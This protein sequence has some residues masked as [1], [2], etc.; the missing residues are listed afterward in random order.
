VLIARAVTPAGLS[1]GVV[2][3]DTFKLIRGEPFGEIELATGSFALSEVKLTAPVSPVV[4]LIMMAGFIR[5]EPGT[6]NPSMLGDF[7]QPPGSTRPDI[8]PYLYPKSVVSPCG[9][10][11]DVV[12]QQDLPGPLYIEPELAVVI[13]RKIKAISEEDAMSAVLGFTNFNDVTMGD[14]LP[15]RPRVQHLA[16]G[17][18]F[19]AK[20][21][22]T[23][24][25]VGPYIRTDLTEEQID[26]G[27]L[28][29]G[30][31][32][33]DVRVTGNTRNLKY[34][35]SQTVSYASRYRTLYPGDVISF[36]TP[37]TPPEVDI[38]DTMEVEIEGLRTLRN[39]LRGACAD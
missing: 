11:D 7:V 29:Q 19:Q 3:G 38:G 24:A 27:L 22:D 16:F 31:I 13:G 25:S 35:I 17:D 15:R 21:A 23:S 32:N 37:A 4:F 8:D 20:C 26:A 9:P 18:L 6:G 34:G 33:G 39:T 5:P 28:I 12:R 2:E 10:D 36:G 14:F 1:Y 30:R